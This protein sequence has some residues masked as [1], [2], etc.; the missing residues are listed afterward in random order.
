LVCNRLGMSGLQKLTQMWTQPV[1]PH[2]LPNTCDTQ[3]EDAIE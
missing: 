2:M 1:K 3:Y